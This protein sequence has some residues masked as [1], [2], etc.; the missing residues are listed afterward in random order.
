MN[1]VINNLKTHSNIIIEKPKNLEI[2]SNLNK[3]NNIV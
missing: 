3:I 1:Q 2:N